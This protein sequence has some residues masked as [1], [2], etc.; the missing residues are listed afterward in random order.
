MNSVSI[1]PVMARFRVGFGGVLA[2]GIVRIL[3]V[4]RSCGDSRLQGGHG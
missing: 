1:D 2:V 3:L 4:L